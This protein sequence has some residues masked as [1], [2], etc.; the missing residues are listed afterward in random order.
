M[1][2]IICTMGKIFKN[3]N[4]IHC[5]V[6]KQKSSQKTNHKISFFFK[7]NSQQFVMTH[8][9]HHKPQAFAC[10]TSVTIF[11]NKF[12]FKI[13]V[14]ND[15]FLVGNNLDKYCYVLRIWS[16]IF[17]QHVTG[18]NFVHS[19]KIRCFQDFNPLRMI[20]LHYVT[21]KTKMISQILH[22]LF[23][24]HCLKDYQNDENY[25]NCCLL[26]TRSLFFLFSVVP[27]CLNFAPFMIKKSAIA[28]TQYM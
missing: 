16:F 6:L 27:Q 1:D 17:I 18:Q 11:K 5:L 14:R 13:L 8:C 15:I 28:K 25:I 4:L 10:S 3:D 2:E 20:K 12:S 21:R 24:N 26:L 19:A 23:R 9:P 22:N 7:V